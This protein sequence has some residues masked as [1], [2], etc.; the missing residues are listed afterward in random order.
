MSIQVF[1]IITVFLMA[2][3][4]PIAVSLSLPSI[5]FLLFNDIP[6]G[7]LIQRYFNAMNS[8]VLLCIP[9]FI[10]AGD[11]MGRG[12]IAKRLINFS[13]SIFGNVTGGLAYVTIVACAFF[14]AVTGSGIACCLA[15][16]SIL[17]PDMVNSGYSRPFATSVVASGSIMGPIIPPSIS[18]VVY[19]SMTGASIADL[20]TVGIPAGIFMALVYMIV[21][22][23]MCRSRKAGNYEAPAILKVKKSGLLSRLSLNHCFRQYGRSARRLS[24]LGEFWAA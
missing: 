18:L 3:G 8:M 15:L 17:I 7:M 21:V 2:V 9:F 16:G 10:L 11:I 23:F 1:L 22:F 4:V 14:A 5:L 19:G 6:I 13:K 12:G 20:Y 24:S